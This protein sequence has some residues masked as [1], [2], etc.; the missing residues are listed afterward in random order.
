MRT[1]LR[2]EPEAAGWEPWREAW[3]AE[4]ALEAYNPRVQ[5]STRMREAFAAGD[6]RRFECGEPCQ[7]FI[8]WGGD[9]AVLAFRGTDS[10]EDWRTDANHAMVS[11]P[12]YPGRVHRGFAEALNRGWSSVVHLVSLLPPG[13]PLLATGHSLGGALAVLAAVRLRS[14]GLASPRV[15]TFGQ[16]RPGDRAFCRG[17]A[18]PLWRRV[19]LGGDPVVHLPASLA[20]WRPYAHGG[21]FAWIDDATGAL[22]LSERA[23]ARHRAR[24]RL[25]RGHHHRAEEY[26]DALE[27]LLEINP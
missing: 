6:I 2:V 1:W 8:A 4:C 25:R 10:L 20:L 17:A 19:A 3:L 18:L 26:A 13:L 12:A 27:A 21:A 24:A 7:G 22:D 9:F 16:P 14:A 23:I 11:R 15:V 5:A